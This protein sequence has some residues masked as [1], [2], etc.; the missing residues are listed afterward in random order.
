[1]TEENTTLPPARLGR[2]L[3][4]GFRAAYDALGYVVAASFA[5]FIVCGSLLAAA[6]L[7]AKHTKSP[8]ALLMLLPAMLVA[9]LAQ[10]GMLCFARNVVYDG[11]AT[12]S[13]TW[14][15][16]GKLFWPAVTLF[17]VDLAITA[18]LFGDA[19][20]FLAA[21]K[22]RG[23]GMLAAL[24]VLFVYLSLVWVMM[25]IYHLPVLVAQLEMESGPRVKV[26][27]RKSML[28]AMGNPGFTLGFFVVIIAFTAICA[29]PALLGMA[30]LFPGTAA[31]L[32]TTALRE[33]FIKYGVVEPPPEV[34]EDKPW[35][36]R[37]D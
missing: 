35:K 12:I 24:G 1:M 8:A 6:S 13:D 22:A 34:V 21:F 17:V 11:H 20:F 14:E 9:W 33:L 5:T 7:L 19:A 4:K 27:L 18:V 29:L 37:E 3:A 31:F 36:L 15:G 25:A 28:L 10:V 26:V 2:A 30:I 16:I 23:S 32:L